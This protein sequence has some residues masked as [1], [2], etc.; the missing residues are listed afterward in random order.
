MAEGR[1][2][3]LT[4]YGLFQVSAQILENLLLTLLDFEQDG[5]GHSSIVLPRMNFAR[6]QE[7][8]AQVSDA[9]LGEQHLFVGL[10]HGNSNSTIPRFRKLFEHG[11]RHARRTQ[12][13]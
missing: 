11:L 9:L 1:T 2:N 4:R 3:S 8:C 6:L 7:D 12:R 5:L 10:N 13:V